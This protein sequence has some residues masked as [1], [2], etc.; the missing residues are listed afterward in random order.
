MAL[1]ANTTG[2]QNTALGYRAL[3]S[4]ETADSNTAVGDGCLDLNTT[5]NTNTAVGADALDAN[6]TGNGNTAVGDDCLGKNTTGIYNTAVGANAGAQVIGNNNTFMGFY[7]GKDSDS[8]SNNT[9]FGYYAFCSN[10]NGTTSG[11]YN[12][13]VGRN[14]LQVVSTGDYNTAIGDGAGIYITTGTNNIMLGRGSGGNGSPSGSVTGEDNRICIGNNSITNAHVKVDWTVGSDQRDKTDI[15]DITTGLSFVN[16][17]KP[18]SFW[19]TKERGSTE[20][21]GDK[22]YGFLAQDILALEGSDPVIINNKD[23]DSLKYQGSH[24]IPILVNAIK[25]L[26][27]EVELLKAA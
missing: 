1:T 6:T 26:S 27:A 13:A 19:F 17:L 22:K 21:H 16:Q 10:Q 9:A 25:E 7:S 14:S 5:G 24:L 11:S 12:T 4:N 18:K 3:A 8:G 15:Q 20:K 2:S 23:E